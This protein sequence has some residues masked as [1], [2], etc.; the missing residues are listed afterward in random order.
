MRCGF[1]PH[2]RDRTTETMEQSLVGFG[3]N[4]GGVGL[5]HT[6]GFFGPSVN[7]WSIKR[8]PNDTKLDRRSTGSKPR[9]LGKSRS[10]PEMFNLHTRKKARNDHR[11]RTKRRNAKRTT[12]KNDRMHE[13]NMYANAMH[14]MTWYEMHENENN[15]RRQRPETEK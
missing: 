13:M 9:P 1:R 7:R 8:S 14:V 11:R 5:Q 4:L 10:N 12:G 3:P 6:R 2:D 15:T